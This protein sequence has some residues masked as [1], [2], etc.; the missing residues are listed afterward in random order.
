MSPPSSSSSSCCCR[1][2]A[3]PLLPSPVGRN[4]TPPP[5]V[6]HLFHRQYPS[7]DSCLWLTA[8]CCAVLWCHHLHPPR[9]PS[10]PPPPAAPAAACPAPA[11]AGKWCSWRWESGARPKLEHPQPRPQEGGGVNM[12]VKVLFV[13]LPHV[14]HM[15]WQACAKYYCSD[16]SSTAAL[17]GIVHTVP[18][19][20]E[21]WSPLVLPRGTCCGAVALECEDCRPTSM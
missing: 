9:P 15:A 5:P 16:Y 8:V 2:A 11:A 6:A 14:T 20:Q 21:L 3:L 17:Q 12:H 18:G 7:A 19:R 4:P 1:P 13:V 10:E